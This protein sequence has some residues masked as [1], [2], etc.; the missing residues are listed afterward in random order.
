MFKFLVIVLLCI[1]ALHACAA[2]VSIYAVHLPYDV[3]YI[4]IRY[5]SGFDD[6]YTINLPFAL[7]SDMFWRIW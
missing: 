2:D 1:I 3:N 6:F 7:S 4:A 5:G